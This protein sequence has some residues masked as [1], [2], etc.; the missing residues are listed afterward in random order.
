MAGILRPLKYLALGSLL[1][2]TATPT[3]I[4]QAA[5]VFPGVGL[6]FPNFVGTVGQM[7]RAY[8]QYV[9]IGN[10]WADLGLSTYH[11]LET[12]L[13]RRYA[14]GFTFSQGYTFSKELDN[15]LGTP[16]NPFNA[17]LEKAPGTT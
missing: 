11:V 7:F 12:A 1:T 2:A 10:P 15:L 8:P 9:T 16:R 14:N 3:T 5:A 17:G 4:A 13:S 6:P